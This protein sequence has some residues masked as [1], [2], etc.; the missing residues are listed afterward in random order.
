MGG[1]K[2]RFECVL[3]DAF[4]DNSNIEVLYSN[5]GP[6]KRG[7]Y[8]LK[9]LKQADILGRFT[10]PII[11]VGLEN[12]RDTSTNCTNVCQ[13][14][15]AD[16]INTGR[17][18]LD[19]KSCRY[20]KY[21]S[22]ECQDDH[23]R[24]YHRKE[25]SVIERACD[26]EPFGRLDL[27]HLALIRILA[28]Y[29]CD[30]SFASKVRC[31]TSH[32]DNFL[33][34]NE[35]ALTFN[36]LSSLVAGAGQ[37]PVELVHKVFGTLL[38][39]FINHANKLNE[40]IGFSFDP[41]FSLINHSCVPNTI[42][43]PVSNQSFCLVANKPIGKGS[44]VTTT[45]VHPG[46][47]RLLRQQELM[48]RY[49]FRCSCAS[50]SLSYDW[51]FS[52]NCTRC[53]QAVY[54]LDLQT[55]HLM[56][57]EQLFERMLNECRHCQTPISRKLYQTV[58]Q[59]H[60]SL[61]LMLFDP[62][63]ANKNLHS[64]LPSIVNYPQTAVGYELTVNYVDR[65]ANAI[66]K[67]EELGPAIPLYC[68]PLNIYI[69]S[70]AIWY[71]KIRQQD[72]QNMVEWVKWEFK[73]VFAI[74]I[75]SDISELR[76]VC[77]FHYVGIADCFLEL[78]CYI[79]DC[80]FE[81]KITEPIEEEQTCMLLI[82][83]AYKGAIF[84]YLQALESYT[85]RILD[86]NIRE[87]AR[88]IISKVHFMARLQVSNTTNELR[89]FCA[90]EPVAFTQ[91]MFSSEVHHIFTLFLVP[92]QVFKHNEFKMYFADRTRRTLFKSVDELHCKKYFD[93]V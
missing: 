63:L 66:A 9:P 38:V 44:Q 29:G 4:Q 69:S 24:K 50:C 21:C 12:T 34:S 81:S 59:T 49:F 31:L 84:F 54:S 10:P 1:A 26:D 27:S 30:E 47:P 68:Y 41:E 76:F 61:F 46:S 58:F 55:F 43:V 67:L 75:P 7:V 8:A 15:W 92:V 13:N 36:E 39:N 82:N 19:C 87:I 5:L 73:R 16:L 23:W 57:I 88:D 65:I 64:E 6:S 74:I 71:L 17:S 79:L 62:E 91:N 40:N 32:T 35:W 45:Y 22:P 11:S 14:C 33:D 89:E 85:R 37:Q 78:A 3:D 52:Y 42:M 2:R 90:V 56:A 28:L 18:V 48:A 72:L 25:C 20:C 77:N 86:D 83:L 53:S 80:G 60:K 70:L 51:F 93:I